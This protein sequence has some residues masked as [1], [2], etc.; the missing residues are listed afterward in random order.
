MQY[1]RVGKT[2]AINLGGGAPNVYEE[3]RDMLDLIATKRIIAGMEIKLVGKN[4]LNAEMA[5]TY[6][7]RGKKY[8]YEQYGIGRSISLGLSYTL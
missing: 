6:T 4:V 2:F 8:Y 1:N 5:K 7:Y 3:P